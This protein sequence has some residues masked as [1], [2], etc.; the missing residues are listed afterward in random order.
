MTLERTPLLLEARRKQRH[1]LNRAADLERSRAH[2]SHKKHKSKKTLIQRL[3]DGSSKLPSSSALSPSMTVPLFGMVA[4]SALGG[5]M[6][7]GGIMRHS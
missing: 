1:T 2:T 3:R 4:R 5:P 7:A 6:G